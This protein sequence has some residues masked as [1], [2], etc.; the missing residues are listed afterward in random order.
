MAA[1]LNNELAGASSRQRMGF[2][3]EVSG[4]LGGIDTYLLPPCPFIAA[5]VN[6]SMMPTTERHRELVAYLAAKC[7]ALSKPQMMRVRR[8]STTDQAGLLRNK[9]DM[10]AVPNP[11]RL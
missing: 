2:E 1:A 6:F 7:A 9:S 10:L 4:C 11:A 3:P 5:A 8:S